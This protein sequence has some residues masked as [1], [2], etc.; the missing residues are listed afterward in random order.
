MGVNEEEII[1]NYLNNATGLNQ[2][3][4]NFGEYQ[5]RFKRFV[6]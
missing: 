6:V 2:P 4:T 3:F 1:I 5:F